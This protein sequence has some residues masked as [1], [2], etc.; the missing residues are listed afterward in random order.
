MPF[1][2]QKHS[3]VQVKIKP[4]YLFNLTRCS[5]KLLINYVGFHPKNHPNVLNNCK[6]NEQKD[7]Y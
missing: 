7:A 2:A 5:V 1:Y 4:L 6:Y 3:K